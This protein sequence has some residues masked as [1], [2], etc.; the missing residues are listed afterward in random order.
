MAFFVRPDLF[1]T[2]PLFFFLFPP[3]DEGPLLSLSG[4]IEDEVVED[5]FSLCWCWK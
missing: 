5:G 1:R 3:D 4:R 2:R